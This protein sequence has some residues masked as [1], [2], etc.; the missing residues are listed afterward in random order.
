MAKFI[1]LTSRSIRHKNPIFVNMENVGFFHEEEF[2]EGT[3]LY[4][5]YDIDE[6]TIIVKETPEQIL[7]LIKAY[8]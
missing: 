5:A 3:I 8:E 1:K 2:K 4:Y 7:E 6:S